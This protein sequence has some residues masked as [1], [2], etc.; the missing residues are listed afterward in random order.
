MQSITN[1]N[2]PTNIPELDIFATDLLDG[3]EAIKSINKS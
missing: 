2:P 1:T 3:N